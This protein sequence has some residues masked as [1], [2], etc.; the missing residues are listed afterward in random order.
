MRSE[1]ISQ[2]NMEIS[3]LEKYRGRKISPIT[4]IQNRAADL[5]NRHR[6]AENETGPT[7]GRHFCSIHTATINQAA[8]DS[9]RYI[10]PRAT[11]RF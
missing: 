5:L 10:C 1:T 2:I 6:A 11:G 9:L 7:R 8:S 3:Q 4:T